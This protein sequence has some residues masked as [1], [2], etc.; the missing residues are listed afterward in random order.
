[1]TEE[2]LRKNLIKGVIDEIRGPRFGH[3]EIISYDPWDE[4]LIGT[5]IPIKWKCKKSSPNNEITNESDYKSLEDNS[6]D[7][8]TMGFDSSSILDPSSQIKSFGISFL[9]DSLNPKIDICVTWARYFEDVESAEAIALNEEIIERSNSTTFWKRKS[10]G[11]IISLKISDEYSNGKYVTIE[12]S[13][14]GIIKL[15]IKYH[16]IENKSHVSVYFINDLIPSSYLDSFRP[17]TQDCIFQPSIRINLTENNSLG[18]STHI[19]STNEL[20][21]LYRHKPVLASGHQCSV[22][23]KDIDYYDEFSEFENFLWPDNIHNEENPKFLDFR[24]PDIRTEFVPLY[25]INLPSFDLDIDN[26]ELS[27]EKLS[28]FTQQ[29]LFDNFKILTNYYNNWIDTNS[30][31]EDKF[32]NDENISDDDFNLIFSEGGL[33]DKQ[34]NV[35]DRINKG[36]DLLKSEKLVYLAFC[37]ANKTI[38]KQDIWKKELNSDDSIFEWRAFQIAFILLNLESIW[39]D[40]S[41]D[42]SILDLLWI[43]TG[44]GKTEAYLGLIA[45]TISLRRLKSHFGIS[46][47]KTGAGVSVISRYTLRLLTVQQFRRTLRMITAAETLRVYKCDNGAIGW[48]PKN[49]IL[50]DDWIYGSVRFSVGMWVGGAVTPLH[51]SKERGAMAILAENQSNDATGNPAQIIKC[52]VCGSWLSV[53]KDGLTDDSNKIHIVIGSEK[54]EDQ[55]K[56]DLSDFESLEYIDSPIKITSNNHKEGFYTLS[57]IINRPISQNKFKSLMRNLKELF[58]VKSLGDCSIGYIP[59][60]GQLG[61]K[62]AL[63]TDYEIWCTNPYDD[64]DLN[65]YWNE[66]CPTENKNGFT[67]PDGNY[68]REIISPYIEGSKIPIPA[69]LIDEHVYYRCPSVVVSTADKIARLSFEPRAAAIF[70][71]INQYNQYYG[72]CRTNL[73]PY[74]ESELCIKNEYNT[75]IEPFSAPDL[76]IQDELHLMNGPL[77]SLF[78]L[79]E[80]VVNALIK[81]QGGNPKYIASTATINNAEHQSKMLFSKKVSQFPPYGFD[82]SNSFFVKDS[83]K[84]IW[85]KSDKGRIYLGIYAPGMGSFTH[86]IRIYSRLLKTA[87]DNFNHEK[88]FNYWTLVGYYNTIRELGSAVALY[89]DNLRA[90]IKHIS[91]K[92]NVREIQP[93]GDEIELSSRIDSTE[94]P[95]ILDNLERDGGNEPPNYNAIFTTSMFGTGVDISHLSTMVMNAQPKTTGDYIQ[96]TG[97][98]GRSDGGLVVDLFRSGRP[99][100]LNHYEMF[101]SYHS[102]IYREVEPIAVSPFSEGCLAKGLGPSLVA[103]LRNAKNL[104]M[105]WTNRTNARVIL[106]EDADEDIRYYKNFL[107]SHLRN[108]DFS[109]MKI[110]NILSKFN[111]EVLKWKSCAQLTDSLYY[112]EYI[113]NNAKPRHDVVLGDPI[114]EIDNKFETVYKNAPQSLRE[115]EDTL[116]FSV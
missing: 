79:Y 82:I 48:R 40:K 87:N 11:E 111:E 72:Y 6:T 60:R 78:G 47:E 54:N 5:I 53:P 13:D 104:K 35:L 17:E 25:P 56:K 15:F 52:P 83:V 22:L 66:G 112:Y 68:E 29:E 62:S 37:F 64:C 9:V 77:G 81:K 115:V 95:I 23:W 107:C 44:G 30:S 41:I 42:K 97:R 14:E 27:P 31:Q 26:L 89:K 90:R 114:H 110:N 61:N 91:V 34:K 45:F 84:N 7:A 55:I 49:C 19:K 1:M 80:V 116:E 100:D 33:L 71:N 57:L 39:N 59:S 88:I 50:D 28:E 12:E 113:V 96:A 36:I 86:Q 18:M 32:K 105:D 103:F 69:Y 63:N 24:K 99:R 101:S 98:I 102:R 20:D 4:Y 38:S 92:D 76:I 16:K 10:Y 94:L 51:L 109:D 3:D 70:G 106:D 75:N 108:M 74:D 58:E 8:K 93:D 2:D 21:L 67:F 73:F 43:P 65:N 85:E 46:N